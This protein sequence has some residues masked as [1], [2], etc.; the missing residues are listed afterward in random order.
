M[1][2]NLNVLNCT[3]VSE[4]IASRSIRKERLEF[5]KLKKI[6]PKLASRH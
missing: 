4:R 1:K 2:I 5:M 3:E 6:S